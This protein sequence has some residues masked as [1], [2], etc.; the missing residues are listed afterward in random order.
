VPVFDIRALPDDVAALRELDLACRDWVFQITGH[1]IPP[2]VGCRPRRCRH[3]FAPDTAKQA[4]ARTA[5]MRGLLRS[6]ADENRRDWKQVFDVGPAIDEVLSPAPSH[7]GQLVADF[8]RRP[9]VGRL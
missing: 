9:V 2:P 3:F 8:V 6:G 1:G 5:A 7:N 4:V